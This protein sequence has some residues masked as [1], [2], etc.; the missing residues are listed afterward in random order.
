LLD[1]SSDEAGTTLETYEAG[2]RQVLPKPFVPDTLI[3]A[4]KSELRGP[5]IASVIS[6]ATRIKMR[7]LVFDAMQRTIKN[8]EANVSFLPD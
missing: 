3:G 4:I 1:E 8:G 7:G 5:E 2:A 6:I